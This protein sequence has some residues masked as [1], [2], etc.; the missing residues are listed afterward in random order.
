MGMGRKR[1]TMGVRR[2]KNQRKK[3]E[4]IK[5]RIEAAKTVKS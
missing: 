3:K 5:K 4:R 2:K 1:Q